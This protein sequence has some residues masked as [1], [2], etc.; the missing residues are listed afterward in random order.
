MD[1]RALRAAGLPATDLAPVIAGEND[2]LVFAT[3]SGAH[4]YGFPSRDSDVDLRGAHLLPVRELVG[5]REPEETRSR[6]WDRDGVEMDLVSHDLRKFA[7]LMLRRNGYVLEQLLSPLVV[8]TTPVHQE[9]AALAPDVLTRFHAHH[10]RGFART[11]WR[12]FEKTGELK[13]LLYTLRVLLTGIHLMGSGEVVAHLPTLTEELD[14]PAYVPELI[15]AKARAEHGP[16]GEVVA[17]GRLHADV[18]ALHTRLDEAE[19]ASRLP[20]APS[21]YDALADLVVRAR[22]GA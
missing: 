11:Q 8:H 17:A 2:P 1:E 6:M 10:Y 15:E 18:R 16:A 22:V 12:L 14:A 19:A 4:L 9:L 21:A 7:R 13:P 3:V 5:L 20:D